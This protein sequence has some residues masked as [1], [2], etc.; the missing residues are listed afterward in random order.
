MCFDKNILLYDAEAL[1]L[2]FKRKA[3]VTL[4]VLE[5]RQG[6]HMKAGFEKD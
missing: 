4:T 2:C 1:G 5:L 6:C 3:D